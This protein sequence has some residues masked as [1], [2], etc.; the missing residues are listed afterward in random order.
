M[1]MVVRAFLLG[2]RMIGYPRYVVFHALQAHELFAT[3]NTVEVELRER[4]PDLIVL[5][6]Y[7]SE[8]GFHCGRSRNESCDATAK[9]PRLGEAHPLQGAS[10]LGS[11]LCWVEFQPLQ[12]SSTVVDGALELL[13][14]PFKVCAELLTVT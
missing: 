11:S 3:Q 2:K 14:I 10:H 8:V 5:P 7:H 13:K 9:L 1:A 6:I 4:T 12:A